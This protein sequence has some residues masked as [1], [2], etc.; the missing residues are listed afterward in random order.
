VRTAFLLLIVVA[1]IIV[2]LGAANTS[3]KFDFDVVFGTWTA[4]SLIWVAAVFAGVVLVVGLVAA[5]LAQREASRTRR[6]LE[7]ELQ[8][9]Y[10]R[11]RAAEAKLPKEPKESPEAPESQEAPEGP[12]SA[13]EHDTS[14]GAAGED[15]VPPAG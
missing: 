5:W 8:A 15:A 9:T 4:V 10:E 12:S 7:A 13:S 1:L 6:R 11:L 3:I 2:G 14:P